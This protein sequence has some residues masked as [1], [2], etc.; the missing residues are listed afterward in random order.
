MGSASGS[1]SRTGDCGRNGKAG[2]VRASVGQV[3]QVGQVGVIVGC[4][5][6]LGLTKQFFRDTR[7]FRKK[8]RAYV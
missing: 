1:A 2:N 6:M 5:Y 3:G 7:L 4:E 8:I